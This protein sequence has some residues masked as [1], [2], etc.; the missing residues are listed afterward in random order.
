MSN[1]YEKTGTIYWYDQYALNEAETAFSKYDPNRILRELLY[2]NADIYA[3][4]AANQ[5][6]IAYYPSK[7]I[8]KHPNLGDHDYV[9]EIVSRLRKKGKKV[10]LYVNWLDSKHPEWNLIPLPEDN[11][12]ESVQKDYPLVSWAEPSK[13]EWSVRKI[14]G[15]KWQN[16]CMNSPKRVLMKNIIKELAEKYE[17]DGFHLDMFFHTCVCVCSYCKPFLKKIFG[18]ED[19]TWDIIKKKWHDYIEWRFERSSSYIKEIT[20]VL[21]SHNKNIISLHNAFSPLAMPA[22]SGLSEEWLPHLDVYLSECFDVFE[23]QY[24]DM[25]SA[26]LQV[27]FH[28]AV[29]KP[30]WILLTST[31][32]K[33][34]HSPISKA[35]FLMYAAAAKVNG[36]QIFGPCGVGARQDT[37][38]DKRL[39]RI[40]RD[41][42]SFW[43]RDSGKSD[44]LKS[45]ATTA[46]VY[47]FSTR[48]YYEPGISPVQY[49]G[50]FN[51]WCRMLIEKHVPFNIEIAEF[52]DDAT[53]QKYDVLILPN[54]ACIDYTFEQVVRKFV[55][56]GGKIVAT[57]QTSLYDNKGERKGNFGLSDVLGISCPIPYESNHFYMEDRVEPIIC[58]GYAQCVKTKARVLTRLVRT[59]PSGSS[60]GD[61]DPLPLERT[62]WPL[63]TI[64]IW[65]KGK[66]YYVAWEAGKFYMDHGYWQ[67]AEWMSGVLN[68]V[69]ENLFTTNAPRTVEIMLWKDE[70][71]NRFVFKFSNR[72]V[73]QAIPTRHT[74]S[75]IGEIIPLNNIKLVLK[76]RFK[77]IKAFSLETNVK[78]VENGDEINIFLERLGAYASVV[79]EGL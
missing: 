28:K 33:F 10:V 21:K 18:K 53:A 59:D 56:K 67:T 45:A 61:I 76:K 36:C 74:R 79:V 42:F 55:A 5:F 44:N 31:P 66:A 70:Q 69:I 51:G 1:W 78:V 73:P 64:N 75:D 20:E 9:G 43:N 15:G 29:K 72:T 14:P 47:S 48:A 11:T 24:A 77:K 57:A 39:L 17:F 54:T 71:R 16:P 37:T 38:T 32:L 60:S 68:D 34:G 6:N 41:I 7:F 49:L 63:Y 52:L 22:V 26:S 46:V 25:N 62:D 13:E 3:I 2:V 27:K 58:G 65:D 12:I 35:K 50:E 19:I 40:A 23:C 4:Y 30:S 8:P